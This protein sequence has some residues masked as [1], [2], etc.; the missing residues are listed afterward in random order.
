MSCNANNKGKKQRRV[1]EQA[2]AGLQSPPEAVPLTCFGVDRPA[3]R[4]LFDAMGVSKGGEEE[5]GECDLYNV[6]G[7]CLH[8]VSD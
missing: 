7:Q 8:G 6:G 1:P 2:E 5:R 4:Y 3:I